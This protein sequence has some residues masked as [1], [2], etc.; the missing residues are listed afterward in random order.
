M[1]L[2]KRFGV[3]RSIILPVCFSMILMMN[4]PLKGLA[5]ET[6]PEPAAEGASVESIPD[7][8]ENESSLPEE[9]KFND[10]DETG[11]E[12]EGQDEA[13]TDPADQYNKDADST[14]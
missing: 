3:V 5:Q 8:Q 12:P 11:I 10:L 1:N 13:D 14:D 9:F 2:R 6:I 4:L 7:E